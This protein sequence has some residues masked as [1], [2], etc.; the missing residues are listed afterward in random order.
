MSNGIINALA[1]EAFKVLCSLA[2][3]RA[4]VLR[5]KANCHVEKYPANMFYQIFF[6]ILKEYVYRRLT[7]E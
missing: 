5:Y 3:S 7:S 1:S 6:T 2:R 4:I